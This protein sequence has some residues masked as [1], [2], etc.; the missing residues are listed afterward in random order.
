MM[1]KMTKNSHK[2]WKSKN[3]FKNNEKNLNKNK[4]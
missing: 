1:L 2:K 3:K 4:I